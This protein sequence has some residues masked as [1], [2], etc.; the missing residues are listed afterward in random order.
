MVSHGLPHSFSVGKRSV[1]GLNAGLLGLPIQKGR[2]SVLSYFM[3]EDRLLEL[4][5]K[6]AARLSE[7]G[8]RRSDWILLYRFAE[9]TIAFER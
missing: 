1:A 4:G 9:H 8:G 7:V 6:D 2:L 5:R 3:G